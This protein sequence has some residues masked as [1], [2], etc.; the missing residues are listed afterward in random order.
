M[1]AILHTPH[2]RTSP[3]PKKKIA[4]IL[5]FRDMRFCKQ[6]SQFLHTPPNPPKKKFASMHL[7]LPGHAILQATATTF[8]Y[9]YRHSKKP[10]HRNNHHKLRILTHKQPPHILHKPSSLLCFSVRVIQICKYDSCRPWKMSLYGHHNYKY[11]FC[12]YIYIFIYLI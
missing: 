4:S 3:P 9:P 2:A 10:G 5:C 11:K 7:V 1:S 6:P 12:K 8:A